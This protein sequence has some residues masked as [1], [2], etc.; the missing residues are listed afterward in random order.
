MAWNLN[1][2]THVTNAPA[3]AS[4]PEGFTFASQNTEHVVYRSADGHVISLSPP[5][6]DFGRKALRSA[7]QLANSSRA[8]RLDGLGDGH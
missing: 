5:G 4:R 7:Q 8:V 3:A 6:V 2:L 1:D